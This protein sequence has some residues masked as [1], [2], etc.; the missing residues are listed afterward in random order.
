LFRKIKLTDDSK[1]RFKKLMIL[2]N[3]RFFVYHCSGSTS[4]EAADPSPRF[5]LEEPLEEGL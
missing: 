4:N 5:V 2:K 1:F 3:P